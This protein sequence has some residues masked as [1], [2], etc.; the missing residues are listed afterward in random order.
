MNELQEN[1]EQDKENADKV[2]KK[3]SDGIYDKA[4]SEETGSMP[5]DP[6]ANAKKTSPEQDAGEKEDTRLFADN[7]K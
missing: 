6:A 4:G 1:R 3:A 5:N 2:D 7:G